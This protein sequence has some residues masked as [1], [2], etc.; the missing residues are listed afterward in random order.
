MTN[1]DKRFN[2][3]II[4]VIVIIIKALSNQVTVIGFS[5]ET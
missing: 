1:G 4:I 5:R 3:S 2:V